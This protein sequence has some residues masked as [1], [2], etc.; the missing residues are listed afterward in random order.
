MDQVVKKVFPDAALS[1]CS[2]SS[3]GG[4]EGPGVVR[5]HQRGHQWDHVESKVD[6][7]MKQKN[8]VY[9]EVYAVLLPRCCLV[10]VVMV[11]IP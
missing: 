7:Q 5:D 11:G 6:N 4:S 10:F 1:S 3:S 2:S 9:Q 8:A